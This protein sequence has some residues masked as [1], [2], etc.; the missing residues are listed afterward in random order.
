[1]KRMNLSTNEPFQFGFRIRL[2]RQS[3]S[4]SSTDATV[5]ILRS[6][7]SGLNSSH[8][9]KLMIERD[10]HDVNIIFSISP[11]SLRVVF[12]L[13]FDAFFGQE[14]IYTK[15]EL[16]PPITLEIIIPPN[17]KLSGRNIDDAGKLADILVLAEMLAPAEAIYQQ[18]LTEYVD[19]YGELTPAAESNLDLLGQRFGLSDKKVS[20]LKSAVLQPLKTL[21]DKYNYFRELLVNCKSEKNLSGEYRRILRDQA[22]AIHL[23]EKDLRFL[24]DERRQQILN[25]KGLSD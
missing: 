15:T 6:S 3:M 20:E 4:Q 10:E 13:L 25:Q 7:I 22:N 2:S 8:I 23:P 16:V 1:M 14:Y 21:E 19:F 24:I 9:I 5:E 18:K 17:S 12:K 11:D